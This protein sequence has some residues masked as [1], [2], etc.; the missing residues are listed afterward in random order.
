LPAPARGRNGG[1]PVGF[2]ESAYSCDLGRR[3]EHGR[4]A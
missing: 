1:L 4:G 2:Q 3:A